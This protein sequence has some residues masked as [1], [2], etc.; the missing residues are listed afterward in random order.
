MT[1][2]VVAKYIKS[3]PNI[4]YSLVYPMWYFDNV[5]LF[6]KKREDNKIIVTFPFPDGLKMVG[7]GSEQYGEWAVAAFRDPEK[8]DKKSIQCLGECLTPEEMAKTL[9]EHLGVQ[10][11]T[12]HLTV[13]QFKSEE[14]KKTL[15]HELWLNY[16]A[17][18]QINL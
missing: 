12:A 6:P 8:W 11:E 18:I 7:F 9:S 1:L 5:L 16:L 4:Q 10:V 14:F 15:L 2:I 3:L 17:I 13:E